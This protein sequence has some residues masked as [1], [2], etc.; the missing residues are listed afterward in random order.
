MHKVDLYNEDTKITI[1]GDKIKLSKGAI[2]KGI[3]SIDSFSFSILPSNDGFNNINDFKSIIKVFNNKRKKYE[4]QGRVLYSKPSMDTSGKISKEVVCE[5]FLGYLNDST[6]PYVAEKNWTVEE[7]LSYLISVHNEQVEEYKK[8]KIG[9]ITVTEKNNNIYIGIQKNS[10]Y[11]CIKEKLISNIGGELQ[12]RVE[13]DSIYIDYLTEI[14]SRKN[15]AIERCKNM[16]SISKE[17]NPSN[18][19]TRLYPYGAKIKDSKGNDT[20]ERIDI[21]SVN[22]GLKYIED[23][24]A[25]LAYGVHSGFVEYDDVT[26]P[27]NLLTKAKSYLTENNKIQQKYSITALDLSIIDLDYDDFEVGNYYP[28]KNSILNINDELRILKKTIDI[29]N[30]TSSTLEFGDK[31]YS[32]SDIQISSD[33]KINE[34]TNSIKKIGGTYT[35]EKVVQEIVSSEINSSNS[36]IKCSLKENIDVSNEKKQ[37]YFG[38]VD[39]VSGNSFDIYNGNIRVLSNA[40]YIKVYGMVNLL[41]DFVPKDNIELELEYDSDSITIQHN[42]IENNETIILSPMIIPVAKGSLVKLNI[43]NCTENRGIVKGDSFFTYLI[44]EFFQ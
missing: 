43:K 35:T 21:S 38:L 32:L 14:G 17:S 26:E 4:F 25:V 10:T 6:Q 11:K 44:A 19:I 18:F 42:L 16:K 3:N 29:C 34:A 20:E 31:L 12:L 36:F 24:D 13:E 7:L 41:Q 9:N 8:F 33:K 39:I 28:V 15:T 23:T 22:N 27:S 5:N 37:I 40:R 1:H 2:A 30:P